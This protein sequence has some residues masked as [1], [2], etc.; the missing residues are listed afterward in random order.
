[1]ETIKSPKTEYEIAKLAIE[2]W[3]DLGRGGERW[4]GVREWEEIVEM[5]LGG[6]TE[7]VVGDDEAVMGSSGRKK[8][9][10]V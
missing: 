9:K 1:M 2:R 6:A 8:G 10:K 3:R 7:S 4:N 5:E